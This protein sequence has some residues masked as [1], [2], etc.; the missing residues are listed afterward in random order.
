[1]AFE[2][3]K[4]FTANLTL[5]FL[6]ID[7]HL[8]VNLLQYRVPWYH[9]QEVGYLTRG[10]FRNIDCEFADCIFCARGLVYAGG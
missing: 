3:Y 4:T 5:N 10:S 7:W 8:H 1:M 9:R 6:L 2:I